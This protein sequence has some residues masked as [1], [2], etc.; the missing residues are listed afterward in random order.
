MPHKA[1]RN[2]YH[3]VQSQGFLREDP[4]PVSHPGLI[5]REDHHMPP[6]PV[7]LIGVVLVGEE[8]S[9]LVPRP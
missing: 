6:G 4:E 1:R 5:I 8:K 2:I 7:P 9:E 3:L